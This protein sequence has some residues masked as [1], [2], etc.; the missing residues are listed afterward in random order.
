MLQD[1]CE[2]A[3][4]KHDDD[5]LSPFC[6]I[7]ICCI[8]SANLAPPPANITDIMLTNA[9]ETQALRET[10]RNEA[11]RKAVN[12]INTWHES[13]M[14]A[15]MNDLVNCITTPD[16][17][18]KTLA[19]DIGNLDPRI[20]AWVTA[21]HAPLRKAAIQ[22]VMKEAV[23]DCIVP[24]AEELLESE[25]MRRQTEIE[26]E[27]RQRSDN[28][29]AELRRSA[30][31]YAQRLEQELQDN[32]E[33]HLANLK[34]QLDEKLADDITKIKNQ[35]KVSL[36]A[37]KDKAETHSLTLAIHTP[38]ATK[39]S[40]LSLTHPKKT[41]KKKITV[42]D[43]T[44]PPPPN[45]GPLSSDHTDM[46]T[47]ADSTPTTPVCRSSAPSPAQIPTVAPDTINTDIAD[48]N[49]IPQ[50]AQTPSP[51]E[52]TPHAPTFPA[53]TLPNAPTTNPDMANILTAITSI[54]TELI[55]RIDK[56]NA[57][58]DQSSGP[59]TIA[60]YT[61]W[62]DANLSA[63]EHLGYIDPDHD[64]DMEALAEANA[65][66]EA[67]ELKAQV[68]FRTLHAQFVAEKRM[69][70]LENNDCYLEK[71]YKVCSDLCKS[72]SWNLLALP[73]I[74]DDTIL[75]SWHCAKTV[76][77][78]EEYNLSTYM[79]FE[80][81]TGTKPNTVSTAS[82]TC[83]NTF[84]M[85]YNTFCAKN[86][87]PAHKG[88]PETQDQFFKYVLARSPA[89]GPTTKAVNPNPTPKSVHFTS[90]PPIETLS[91]P[92]SPEDFPVLRTPS[93]EPISY[94]STASSFIPITRRRCGKT[95]MPVNPPT[96]ANPPNQ[97][98]PTA[99]QSGPPP[100]SPKSLRPTKPPLPDALK[101][102]KHT[103]ILDHTNADT[104]ALYALD[105]GELTRGLQHHLEAVKAP[106]VLLAGAWSTT[107]FYKNFILTF[108][109]IVQYTDITK[110]NS[111]LFG[112]FGSNCRAAPMAGYQSIL[113]S[114]VR[115]QRDMHS[116]LASPK[117]LF[118]E[119]CHNP[120]F[121][122]CLP[123]TA[124]RWLFNPDKLLESDKQASSITFSFHD[125]TGEGLEL[126]KRSRVGMFGKLVSIPSWEA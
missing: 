97:M 91:V 1:F 35:M 64:Q 99:K 36:Q 68:A 16:P 4:D 102:T 13:Q 19:R 93:K 87:F 40:P 112:P 23:E 31:A 59:Q 111:I 98:K 54:R 29:E 117:M 17:D 8:E 88:F 67:A 57:H 96:P 123:L 80:R 86:N 92:P 44:T 24:H 58:V 55:D 49:S 114:G 38:K 28:Y 72:M 9:L 18:I 10:L 83:F 34:A 60:E 107:P 73:S 32:T 89:S 119:L 121:V 116:K 66:H 25:W 82:R 125:L 46:E 108:S 109:G 100:A 85:A 103:I 118:D 45:N 43:L 104:K 26:Q 50:W 42:L 90:A 52:K 3:K 53:P 56:V 95:P 69:S 15:M 126:M 21:I 37:A 51:D 61:A 122:S 20:A 79:I 84:L 76:L 22:T 12:D 33:Q 27:L 7:C 71:W 75:N 30:E 124:P 70:S 14:E 101:T 5:H 110:Y 120:V 48:P 105:A 2:A 106:L 74:A 39:P 62:N 115:L 78:E 81:I 94:A 113:I 77:N 6:T 41:K 65:A 11:I 47:E 63:W